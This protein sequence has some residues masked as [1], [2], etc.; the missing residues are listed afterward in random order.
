MELK[1]V[2]ET[3]LERGNA[4]GHSTSSFKVILER[5]ATVT[6]KCQAFYEEAITT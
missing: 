6:S 1:A 2:A 3:V 4:D 5:P